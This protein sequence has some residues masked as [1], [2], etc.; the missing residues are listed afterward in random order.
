MARISTQILET[1]LEHTVNWFFSVENTHAANDRVLRLMD[2]LELPNC[3]R[4]SPEVL[5]TSSDGQKFE[6]R[7]D[8]LNANYSFKYFGKG[9][10]GK[11]LL[12]DRLLV[13][14][15]V[16][17]VSRQACQDTLR[18]MQTLCDRVMQIQRIGFGV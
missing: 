16:L 14:D 17:I 6:V 5:H 12:P 13:Q 3:Y 7:A 2:R 9:R 15:R 1:E 11:C 4:R 10:G 8:S 18:L